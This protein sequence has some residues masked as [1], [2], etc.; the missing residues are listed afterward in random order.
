MLIISDLKD[1]TE[2]FLNNTVKN[3]VEAD[4]EESIWRE[5]LE[6]CVWENIGQP[7]LVTPEESSILFHGTSENVVGEVFAGAGFGL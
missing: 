5:Q 6:E 1:Q 7:I 2:T 3:R 4:S